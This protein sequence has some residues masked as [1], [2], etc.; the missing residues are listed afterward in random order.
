MN[1]DR[2][3]RIVQLFEIVEELKDGQLSIIEDVAIQLA[4]PNI[5]I[6][7]LDTS[8]FIIEIYLKRSMNVDSE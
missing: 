3:E 5:H 6:E 2:R 8:D 1:L 4:K 7:R